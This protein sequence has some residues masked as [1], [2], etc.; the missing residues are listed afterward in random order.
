MK[1]YLLFL[2]VF[3]LPQIA[4]AQEYQT[5]NKNFIKSITVEGGPIAT[6]HFQSGDENFRETHI[7]GIVK[8][9]TYDYG[10][11]ALYYLG[12][13]SVNDT[14]LG[15]GYVT[16]PWVVPVGPTALEF[17]GALGL[18]TGYQDYPVPLIAAEV[19]WQLYQANN[20]DFGISAAAMPYFVE[21]ESTGDNDFGIVV[22]SPFLSARYNF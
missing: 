21:E 2:L 17:S 5:E 14:S 3:I 12:P 9:H 7:L 11:W 19:R 10:N 13:N 16:N 4:V 22:T 6:K 18:V 15:F 8:A 1:K 20:W